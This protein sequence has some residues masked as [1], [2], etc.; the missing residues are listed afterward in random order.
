MLPKVYSTA[1]NLSNSDFM[2]WSLMLLGDA[3]IPAGRLLCA[4][5]GHSGASAS[6]PIADIVWRLPI[7]A[8]W[9]DYTLLIMSV[10]PL[11]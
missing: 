7:M 5:L 9:L 8:G 11:A 4:Y 3:F 2:G 10:A 6:V 1:E